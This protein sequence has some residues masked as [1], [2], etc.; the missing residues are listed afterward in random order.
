MGNHTMADVASWRLPLVEFEKSLV[1]VDK[2]L[3]PFF[4]RDDSGA[5]T[6]WFRPVAASHHPIPAFCFPSHLPPP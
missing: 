1:G 3:E 2:K 4:H 5:T 6:K